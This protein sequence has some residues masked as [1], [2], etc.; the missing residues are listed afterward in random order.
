M[1]KIRLTYSSPLNITFRGEEEWEDDWLDNWDELAEHEQ[2][3]YIA[4]IIID[5]VGTNV[6]VNVEVIP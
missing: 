2:D 1:A 6:D 3:D 4:E 5:W